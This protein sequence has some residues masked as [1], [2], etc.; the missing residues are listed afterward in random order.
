VTGRVLVTVRCRKHGHRLAQ[1]LAAP[2]GMHIHIPHIAVGHAKG[3]QVVNR[4]AGPLV[5]PL[6]D[7]DGEPSMSYPSMCADGV[8]IIHSRNLAAAAAART[9]I[10]T[11]APVLR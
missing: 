7:E 10:I 4:P 2:D 6:L 5:V 9:T 1:L 3:N 11:L 8:H